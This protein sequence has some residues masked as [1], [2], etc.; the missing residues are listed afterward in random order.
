MASVD[1]VR[2]SDGHVQLKPQSDVDGALTWKVY[3]TGSE[4]ALGA[5]TLVDATTV[6]ASTPQWRRAKV[7]FD[8]SPKADSALVQ[9]LA[10]AVRLV[11]QWAFA[12]LSCIVVSWMGPATSASRAVVHAAGFRIQPLPARKAWDGD[13]GPSDAWVADLL[14][15]DAEP[16]GFRPLTAREH[17]VLTLMATG[18]SNQQISKSLGISENTAKNHV[19][20]VL[21]ALQAPSRTAAVVIALRA[22]LVGISFDDAS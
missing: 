22:G 1:Q 3:R 16:S 15:E 7:A 14:P 8:V 19:R 4:T 10:Q 5:V 11:C 21:D 17:Q 12:E 13:D 9:A 18:K 2:L 20:A 6:G